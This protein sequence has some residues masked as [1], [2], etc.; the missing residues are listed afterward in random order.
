MENQIRSKIVEAMAE[1]PLKDPVDYEI[2]SGPIN[3]GV[4]V[5]FFLSSGRTLFVKIARSDF[6]KEDS[7]YVPEHQEMINLITGHINDIIFERTVLE[8]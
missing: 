5:T 8:V 1:I 6:Y 3:S 4:D 7:A 2:Y